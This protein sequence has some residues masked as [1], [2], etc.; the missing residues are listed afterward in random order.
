MTIQ[1]TKLTLKGGARQP[2]L[3]QDSSKGSSKGRVGKRPYEGV[4][5]A[6]ISKHPF[7][8]AGNP[9]L[10]TPVKKLGPLP[11]F[12]NVGDCLD[13]FKR[14]YNQF[15]AY[16]TKERVKLAIGDFSGIESLLKRFERLDAVVVMLQEKL[17]DPSLSNVEREK[18]RK[19]LDKG[20][21][22]LYTAAHSKIVQ[23]E[24]LIEEGKT[25]DDAQVRF[26]TAEVK[27]RLKVLKANVKKMG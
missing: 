22:Y 12:P 7:R 20:V 6:K 23:I 18:L 10:F 13:Q 26:I 15:N 8:N 4:Q 2:R 27:S 19:V 3:S 14:A 9:A 1:K 21:S 24:R 11:F 25:F 17:K 16:F 5:N